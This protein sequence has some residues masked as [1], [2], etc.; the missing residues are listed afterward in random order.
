MISAVSDP[1]YVYLIN[2]SD[3]FTDIA[4]IHEFWAKTMIAE[5]EDFNVKHNK[6]EMIRKRLKKIRDVSI[7]TINP[8]IIKNFKQNA[9]E[10]IQYDLSDKNMTEKE[11]I[12]HVLRTFGIVVNVAH[13]ID[14]YSSNT[15]LLEVSA[16]VKIQS[17]HSHRLDIANVLDVTSIRIMGNLKVYNG[18][19]YVSFECSKKRNKDLIFDKSYLQGLKIPIGVDNYNQTIVWDLENHST[20]HMLICGATGSGKSVSIRSTIE[21]L[22]LAGVNNIIVLDPKYEF[23]NITGCQVYNDIEDIEK[24]MENQVL[25]MNELVK[26]GKKE[27]TAI[28]FD[29]FADA[30]SSS[31]S[32]KELDVFEVIEEQTTRGIRTKRVLSHRMK[33]LEENLKILLQKGRSSGFRIISATQRASVKVITGDAK[34][35]F[36][37][38]ICFRVPKDIDS[39]VVLD[40]GGAES[41]TGMGDGLIKSPEYSDI[42]RFQAFYIP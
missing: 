33:S 40:E 26:N 28:V 32:G 34:V 4:E 5:V 23:K 31:K 38:V 11:K 16:G 17:I 14:G 41:L 18:K 10:F 19:S 24:E 21:Y 27:M 36:P 12:E 15:Y 8:K 7:A 6:K 1:D 9:S 13:I 22:K 37:V 2:E 29:E 42:V 35:N 25:R 3:S 20:P 30:V 39:K